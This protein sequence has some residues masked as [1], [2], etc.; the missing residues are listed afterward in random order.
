MI[1]T[2]TTIFAAAGLVLA[3]IT[4]TA[5]AAQ[6][7]GGN[8][9]GGSMGGGYHGGHGI[10]VGE[11]HPGGRHGGGHHWGHYPHHF[12]YGYGYGWGGYGGYVVSAY[13]DE[14]RVVFSE[15]R[16]RFVRVCY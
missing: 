10:A 2:K 14:C 15:A 7:K 8:L 13:G 16:G 12:G 9:H 1:T 11:P 4:A 6:A 5:S 3:A